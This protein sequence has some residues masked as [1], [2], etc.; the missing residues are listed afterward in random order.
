MAWVLAA[1]VVV[2][3]SYTEGLPTTVLWAAAAGRA[4]VATDVG[5]TREIITD[6]VSGRLVEARDVDSLLA[7]LD[8]LVVDAELRAA[9]G[10]AARADV[11]ARFDSVGGARRW[12]EALRAS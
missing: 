11:H 9:L 2:N 5:G 3:P 1:D 4:Q 7:A 8:E 10:A 12:I 6:G